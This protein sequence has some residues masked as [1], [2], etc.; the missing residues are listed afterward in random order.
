MVGQRQLHR[1]DHHV[2]VGRSVAAEHAVGQEPRLRRDADDLA[3]TVTV[4]GSD[5]RDVS[6]VTGVGRAGA[7][8]LG[9]VG[10]V[11]VAGQRV[12]VRLRNRL[13]RRAARH[14]V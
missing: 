8:H 7:E 1:V 11:R 14:V 12:A 2:R 4:G 3:V 9:A 6:S 10:H 13:K 5:P